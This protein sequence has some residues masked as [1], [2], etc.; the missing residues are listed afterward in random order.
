MSPVTDETGTLDLQPVL[1]S[2]WT[3]RRQVL[4]A[5]VVA[6]LLTL[7][8][9]FLMPRWFRATAVIM[10]P[11][12]SDLL[13]NMGLAQRA[14]TKFPAFGIL[15]D[16]FTPADTYKAIL[17]SR[18]LQEEIIREFDLQKIYHQKSLEKTIKE[19]KNHYKI[20][21]NP[22]GTIA[23][24]AE[25][26]DP[27]RAAAITN[28]ILVALDRFNV[29]KRNSQARR[30]REF[31]QGRVEQTDSL[32]KQ[33]ELA[34]KLYQEKHRTVAPTSVS[35]A[36]VQSA[37][38]LMARKLSLEVR[39]GVLRSYLRADNE[40]V[41]QAQTEL[42][43]LG[44]RIGSLPSL[45]SDLTRLIR[46]Q[47]IYEQL[48]LLLSAELEQARIRETMDTPTVQVLDPAVPP[49]RHARPHRATLA[50][51]AAIVAFIASAAWYGIRGGREPGRA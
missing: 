39:V 46:D 33:S 36:D 21:L 20:K 2:A 19:L 48:Y 3:Q 6:A 32:L 27:K 47:K 31:L 43:Q 14:L 4:T 44:Q 26:R 10:P 40:Q 29:E 1:R 37:A 17:S 5:T 12:E 18:S 16:Y 49:E 8:I 13:S 45:Q 42:D 30:T 9:A 15:N 51:E 34:L 50:L 38:D 11:E 24:S 7:G 41:V 28:A 25:D 22:D 23:V 35:S